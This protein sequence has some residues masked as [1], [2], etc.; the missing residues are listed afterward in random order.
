MNT[1][2]PKIAQ[3]LF[4]LLNRLPVLGGECPRAQQHRREEE[5]ELGLPELLVHLEA[6]LLD[7]EE[8]AGQVIL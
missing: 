4:M 5:L 2:F 7:D 3:T 1:K 8:G 6:D